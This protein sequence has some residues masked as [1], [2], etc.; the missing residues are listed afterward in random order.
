MLVQKQTKRSCMMKKLEKSEIILQKKIPDWFCHKTSGLLGFW[1]LSKVCLFERPR[2]FYTLYVQLFNVEDTVQCSVKRAVIK[3]VIMTVLWSIVKSIVHVHAQQN[4]SQ[5]SC[6]TDIHPLLSPLH[7][8]AN[9]RGIQKKVGN[10][11]LKC[12][13]ILR[14]ETQIK[15]NEILYNLFC[16]G[17]HKF[18]ITRICLAYK[19][20]HS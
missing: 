5:I 10:I 14:Q 9:T 15:L 2:L 17:L 20:W 1:V 4:R 3:S 13:T 12:F 8:V 11:S 19:K 18:W 6:C 16:Q 7:C